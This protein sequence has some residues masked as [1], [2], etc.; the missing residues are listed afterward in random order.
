V[1]TLNDLLD[2]DQNERAERSAR[3]AGRRAVALIGA[4]FWGV[5]WLL[6]KFVLLTLA[7][8]GGFF[9]GIGWVARRAVW[10]A[11]IWIAAAVKLGWED[12]RRAGGARVPR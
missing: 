2:S 7:A 8:I 3:E 5:G 12:G 1:V 11:L 4:A 6:A 10:P 9:Y